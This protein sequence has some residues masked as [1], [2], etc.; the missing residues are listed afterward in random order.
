MGTDRI[1][2]SQIISVAGLICITRCY[3]I[4]AEVFRGHVLNVSL[5]RLISY[6]GVCMSDL[7]Y[8]LQ[9]L[10]RKSERPDDRMSSCFRT[11]DCFQPKIT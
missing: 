1:V 7:S 9:G 6:W 8:M 4:I 2:I 10:Q 11:A 5:E 3:F